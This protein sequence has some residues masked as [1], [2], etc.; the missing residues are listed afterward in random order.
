MSFRRS[1]L[2]H[3]TGLPREVLVRVARRDRRDL[4]RPVLLAAHRA[5]P[6]PESDSH[7]MESGTATSVWEASSSGAAR[8]GWDEITDLVVHTLP[9][10]H[11]GILLL[12]DAAVSAGRLRHS[13]YTHICAVGV[14]E[15][16]G[17][18][19]AD[20]LVSDLQQFTEGEF[21]TT[22]L[23]SLLARL[24]RAARATVL[25]EIARVTHRWIAA[26]LPIYPQ[27]LAAA[28]RSGCLERPGWWD[29]RF[30]DLGFTP[31]AWPQDAA[32]PLRAFLYERSGVRRWALG[33]GDADDDRRPTTDHRP[34]TRTPEGPTPN[35]QRPTPNA[36]HLNVH[37]ALDV[38]AGNAF[39]WL[40]VEF[41]R[42]LESAGERVSWAASGIT[43]TVPE[44]EQDR[45][46]R[47]M[48]AE[49]GDIHLKWTHYWPQYARAPL[50]GRRNF[51]QFAVNYR[52]RGAREGEWDP[53]MEQIRA[54]G[55]TFLPISR[56]CQEA[57][58]AAGIPEERCPVLPIGHSPEIERVSE[59][60]FLPVERGFRFL[61][62]TNCNDWRR[63][64][65]D[66]LLEAFARAFRPGD[67]ACLVLRD[68]GSNAY[69]ASGYPRALVDR[70]EAVRACGLEV[71]YFSRFLSKEEMVR[72]QRA[73]HA[74][75]AP[76]RGEGFGVKVLDAI[77][78]GL[79]AILP[80][81]SGP[82][83]YCRPDSCFPVPFREVPLED[84]LDTRSLRIGNDPVWC[85]VDVAA[86]A[87]TL[88]A[89]YRDPD[90]AQQRGRQ[91]GAAARREYS[92]STVCRRFAEIAG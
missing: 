43:E 11:G 49:G 32:A 15:R 80:L 76:F 85:E 30:R 47:W 7:A 44:E 73:C 2:P 23:D 87:E 50:A 62:T 81:Y 3:W 60:A 51:E 52:F 40:A 42:A 19:D 25:R 67:D 83:D 64:G 72:F 13:G 34:P 8:P 92:W 90:A 65:T 12:G 35:A 45:L 36:Q 9:D 69:L 58:L 29:T 20:R 53:W 75:V 59:A 54:S 28:P 33:V 10:R 1:V 63:Y 22:A 86:L 55:S 38:S 79:P 46:R 77:A 26:L 31:A 27:A 37:F 57:L 84:C 14:T 74:F 56:F 6:P 16:A 18:P 78:C 89:V 88:R 24:S 71:F 70:I 66:L 82:A 17:E 68:Y 21:A 48:V 39:T 4:L 61:A 91:A 41:A 5:L